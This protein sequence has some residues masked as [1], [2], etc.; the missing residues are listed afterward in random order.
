MGSNFQADHVNTRID[1]Q[2]Q[3]NLFTGCNKKHMKT[4]NDL[5]CAAPGAGAVCRSHAIGADVLNFATLPSTRYLSFNHWK[6]SN[7]SRRSQA[8][9]LHYNWLSGKAAKIQRMRDF[10][11]WLL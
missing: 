1:D 7:K 8:I 9:T 6:H 2:A 5:Q 4:S 11:H 3:W 10:G